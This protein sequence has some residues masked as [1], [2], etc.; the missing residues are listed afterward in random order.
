MQQHPEF[1]ICQLE[2]YEGFAQGMPEV[3]ESGEE[4]LKNTVRIWPHRMKG[5][6]HFLAL[7]RKGEEEAREIR[8]VKTGSVKVAEELTQFF[9][10]VSWEMDWNRLDIHGERVYYM[11]EELPGMK[12]IRFL[13]TG[14]L[15]GELK[16]KRFEPSQAFAMCL[17]KD[18]YMYTIS[19]PLEDDRVIK[20]LKGETI[21]VDDLTGP[22]EKGW[23]LICVDDFPLG[24]GK[25]N[26][27]SVKNKYLPGWRWQS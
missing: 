19:L 17:K 21:D 9:R 13:R 2:G 10:A 5:E 22:K 12:G 26:G 24:W 7:L 3:T 27:G 16:K 15:L 25:L 20:Y 6:G 14:L 4:T 23:Y 18:E 1:H 8:S 11:P